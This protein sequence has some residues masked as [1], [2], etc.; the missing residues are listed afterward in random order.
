MVVKIND[1]LERDID[2]FVGHLRD[3]QCSTFHVCD[4]QRTLR[5]YLKDLHAFNPVDVDRAMITKQLDRI[6]IEN[7]ASTS[8]HCRSHASAFF[9]WL[10]AKGVPLVANPVSGTPTT[11]YKPRE[12]LLTWDE[13]RLIWA[14]LLGV[15]LSDRKNRRQLPY[16]F[17]QCGYVLV[18]N[19]AADDGLW[20]INRK[21][22]GIYANA[23][24]PL[25]E[26]LSV[27]Q[28]LVQG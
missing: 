6:K 12:K 28:K 7:G 21:R 23:R 13:M 26:R 24:L 18:R 4:V 22:R 27:A 25:R 17:E 2:G 16:R 8:R 15:W 1:T 19:D 3:K 9:A 11:S 20:R 10:M 5:R 14:A